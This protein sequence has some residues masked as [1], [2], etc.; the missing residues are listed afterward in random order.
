MVNMEGGRSVQVLYISGELCGSC[1]EV[2]KGVRAKGPYIV[3]C[4]VVW[5]CE[6]MCGK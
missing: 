4:V 3:S 2:C 5:R 1:R 6:G